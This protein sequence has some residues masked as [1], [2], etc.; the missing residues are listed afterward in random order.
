MEYGLGAKSNVI[1]SQD[2]VLF[3]MYL[4]LNKLFNDPRFVVCGF[5]LN[6]SSVLF[7]KFVDHSPLEYISLQ[8]FISSVFLLSSTVFNNSDKMP[9]NLSALLDFD[10]LLL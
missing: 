10:L 4:Q 7:K 6:G 5:F 2:L 8:S 1:K 9:S 3:W